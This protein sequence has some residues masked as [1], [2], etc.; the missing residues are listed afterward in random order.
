MTVETFVLT[1]N[2]CRDIRFL[3]KM[4]VETFFLLQEMTVETFV[5]T[6][7]TFLLQEM[8]VETFFLQEMTVETLVWTENDCR[9]ICFVWKMTVETFFLLQEMTV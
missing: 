1:D 7:E 9:D 8:T 5:L 6:V 3:W 2:D 4:T